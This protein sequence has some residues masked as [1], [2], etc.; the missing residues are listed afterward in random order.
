MASALIRSSASLDF[1]HLIWDEKM[2]EMDRALKTGSGWFDIVQK[3]QQ[4]RLLQVEEE[5]RCIQENRAAPGAWAKN[6][7]L[8]KERANLLVDL[9][10]AHRGSPDC[11]PPLPPR[12][13]TPSRSSAARS[14]PK[15]PKKINKSLGHF[16]VFADSSDSEDE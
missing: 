9:C 14:A 8:V 16:A 13:A 5:M 3:D 10:K 15:A 12:P 6:A 7:A 2:Q 1:S 11:Y 4:E